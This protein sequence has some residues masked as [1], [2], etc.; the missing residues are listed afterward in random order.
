MTNNKAWC[1]DFLV[2]TENKETINNLQIASDLLLL[3]KKELIAFIENKNEKL[4]LTTENKD[5]HEIDFHTFLFF[6]DYEKY[7]I[8]FRDFNNVNINIILEDLLSNSNYLEFD[9]VEDANKKFFF[10]ALLTY[11]N[12][13]LFQKYDI[14][15]NPKFIKKLLLSWAFKE[16]FK[17]TNID[18]IIPEKYQEKF[19]KKLSDEEIIQYNWGAFKKIFK[20]VNEEVKQEYFK[21]VDIVEFLLP[22][23]KLAYG[24][25]YNKEKNSI[26]YKNKKKLTLV[27]NNFEDFFLKNQLIFKEMNLINQKLMFKI[28]IHQSRKDLFEYLFHNYPEIKKENYTEDEYKEIIIINQKSNMNVD[29]DKYFLFKKLN[30]KMTPKIKEKRSKI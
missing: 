4:I 12:E 3:S 7:L 5:K 18:F 19:I 27:K 8:I 21:K 14:E 29:L 1:G 28:F 25:E 13:T 11:F 15:K 20:S 26:V 2:E 23:L 24:Y 30:T 16:I 9:K 17:N 6:Q 10:N 22:I